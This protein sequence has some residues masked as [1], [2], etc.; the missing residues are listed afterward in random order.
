MLV[1]SNENEKF[2]GKNQGTQTIPYEMKHSLK[3]LENYNLHELQRY[4][5]IFKLHSKIRK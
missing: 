5:I 4:M 1:E 3:K 2:F